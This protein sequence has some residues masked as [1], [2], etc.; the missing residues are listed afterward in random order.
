[1]VR[2]Q[3]EILARGAMIQRD[4]LLVCRTRNDP[5]VYL[6][7]GHVE[8]GETA[9]TALAREIEEELGLAARV[10]RFLGA[11]QHSFIQKGERHW[12]IN[13]V[14]EMRV[15]DLQDG[16]VPRAAESHL[17]F[18]WVPLDRLPA[19]KLEPA[20]LCDRLPVWLEY[21]TV[22]RWAEP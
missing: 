2:K 6:P 8:F 5:L 14:F 15:R 10:Q 16:R 13:L 9:R 21:E 1:M 17:S 19:A 4:R 20:A 7:G 22:E 11:V 12:E 3:I 18:D